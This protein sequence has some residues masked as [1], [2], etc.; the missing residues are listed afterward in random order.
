ML[1]PKPASG[2]AA[3]PAIKSLGNPLSLFANY[4]ALIEK[5]PREPQEG[6]TEYKLLMRIYFGKLSRRRQVLVLQHMGML[7]ENG[8]KA[9][10]IYI[11][12]V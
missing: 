4:V 5:M 6:S 2:V 9:L 8:E 7:V 12:M 10:K 11:K 1:W 3:E